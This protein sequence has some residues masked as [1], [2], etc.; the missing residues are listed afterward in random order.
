MLHYE[1]I[2]TQTLELLKQLQS[3]PEFSELRLVGGTSLALQAGH[4]KSVDIDLFGLLTADNI[5]ISKRL[6]NLGDYTIL[7]Q[8][9]NI[10]IF[11]INTIKV[12]IVNYPYKWIENPVVQDHIILADKKD[13]AALKLA[14]I[15]GRGSKKDFIDIYFLLKEFS[16][17]EM[18]KFYDKKY[19]D[20]SK[21]LVLKS[22]LYFNDAEME[23][24][25]EMLT[26]VSWEEI[27]E[28]IF[29]EV[30]KEISI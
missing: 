25:P 11:L 15:T 22:L 8:T 5:T 13:I 24:S 28:T 12:D 4:R 9:E 7:K 23:V 10:H 6:N 29:T 20:G 16:L 21:F 3:I 2:N 18:L 19:P 1:T 17:H 27:K 26:K 14:A 30:N